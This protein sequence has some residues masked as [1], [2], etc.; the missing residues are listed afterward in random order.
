MSPEINSN[1][2]E[3]VSEGRISGSDPQPEI[4][5]YDVCYLWHKKGIFDFWGNGCIII[6]GFDNPFGGK[7]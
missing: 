1:Y 2:I 6:G 7:L 5:L 3:G 4:F